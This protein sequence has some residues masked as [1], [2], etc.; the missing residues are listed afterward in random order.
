MSQQLVSKDV[1]LKKNSK[2]EKRK[3]KKLTTKQTESLG[4]LAPQ[5]KGSINNGNAKAAKHIEK[6]TDARHLIHVVHDPETGEFLVRL[7]KER[8]KGRA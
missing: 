6:P 3:S 2:E 4:N 5:R 7:K 1:P 8:A